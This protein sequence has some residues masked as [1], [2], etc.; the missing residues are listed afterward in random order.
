MCKGYYM[1]FIGNDIICI[2]IKDFNT[3][4]RIINKNIIL[5]V[6]VKIRIIY[7]INV[8][9]YIVNFN[10]C[11]NGYIIRRRWSFWLDDIKG[12]LF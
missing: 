7:S 10:Y 2:Y 8:S 12:M 4:Y 6:I 9:F 1:F 5:R 3:Y 11:I